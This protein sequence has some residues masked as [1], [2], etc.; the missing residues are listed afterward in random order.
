MHW[1]TLPQAAPQANLGTKLVETL[2]GGIPVSDLLQ[3]PLLGQT[4]LAMLRQVADQSG[5]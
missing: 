4:Q 5:D 2:Q 1:R 3:Q